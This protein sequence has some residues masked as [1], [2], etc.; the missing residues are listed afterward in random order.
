MENNKS[1]FL[2][3]N[4]CNLLHSILKKDLNEKFNYQ[5]DD[6]KG[7]TKLLEVMNQVY[8]SNTHQDLKNLNLLSLKTAAPILKDLCEKNI[9]QPSFNDFSRKVD[10]NQN[11]QN[12]MDVNSSLNRNMV[13]QKKIPEFINM[14]PEYLGKTSTNVDDAYQNVNDRYTINKPPP[15]D[16]SL[17]DNSNNKINLDEYQQKRNSE[18][19]ETSISDI[20]TNGMSS[21]IKE[22]KDSNNSHEIIDN[23]DNINNSI[24]KFE[25]NQYELNNK[26]DNEIKK[27]ENIDEKDVSQNNTKNNFQNNFK[28][29]LSQID[30]RN[31]ES[32]QIINEGEHDEINFYRNNEK[33]SEDK[34]GE[35]YNYQNRES[36]KENTV[37]NNDLQNISEKKNLLE[38]SSLDRNWENYPDITK[39]NKNSSRYNFTVN[40]N[41]SQNEWINIPIYENNPFTFLNIFPDGNVIPYSESNIEI[42]R[43]IINNSKV[44]IEVGDPLIIYQNEI[45]NKEYKDKE[46]VRNP[47]YNPEK[48]KG[49]IIYYV[50][51]MVSGNRNANIMTIYKNVTKIELNHIVLPYDYMF[52]SYTS[53]TGDFASKI[54]LVD[55]PINSICKSESIVNAIFQQSTFSHPYLLLH[56]E[57]VDGIY[58]ATSN[59]VE[60]SFCKITIFREWSVNVYAPNSTLACPG[61]LPGFVILKPTSDNGKEYKQ[62]ALA[63]LNKFTIR[64]LNPQGKVISTNNEV[65]IIEQIAFLPVSENKFDRKCLV[66]KSKNWLAANTFLVNHIIKISNYQLMCHSK[67]SKINIGIDLLSEFINRDEGHTII[68]IGHINNKKNIGESPIILDTNTNGYFNVIFIYSDGYFDEDH[69]IYIPSLGN[70]DNL[71]SR[72]IISDELMEYLI[73]PE[74]KGNNYGKVINLSMQTN[75]SFTITNLESNSKIIKSQII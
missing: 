63:S 32:Y 73:L 46:I 18:V 74:L 47:F 8:S 49:Q 42:Y 34:K 2:K 39:I 29:D 64:I 53:K 70:T 30:K 71:E 54:P 66:I 36:H 69:G 24:V 65:A 19:G 59:M 45:Y 56:I 40:F 16:F 61:R 55:G 5:L 25:E 41:A 75:I 33:I 60:K 35:Y 20:L 72:E 21:S 11:S 7:K 58:D 6:V 68:N 26:I 62:S 51:K 31:A 48:D 23:I 43:N 27:I 67:D 1:L 22:L 3:H 37:I 15:I 44:D 52:T 57:E 10:I 38:I 12:K 9:N 28:G 13:L 4:N 50:K 17:S 14:R